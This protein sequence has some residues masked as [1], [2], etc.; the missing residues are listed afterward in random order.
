MPRFGNV[1]APRYFDLRPRLKQ[2]E[3]AP[4][5]AAA[6]QGAGRLSERTCGFPEELTTRHRERVKGTAA[7]AGAEV[8]G[9]AGEDFL[10]QPNKKKNQ[11]RPLDGRPLESTDMLSGGWTRYSG[12][13]VTNANSLSRSI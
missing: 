7:A 1:R 2:I 4:L 5:G 8:R 13:T 3:S 9:G 6:S 12:V 11:G 10:A